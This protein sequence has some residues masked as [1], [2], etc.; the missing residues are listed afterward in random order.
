M[1]DKFIKEAD[2]TKRC[3]TM[4][5][6]KNSTEFMN[7]RRKECK[8][9]VSETEENMGTVGFSQRNLKKYKRARNIHL[10]A[11]R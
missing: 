3:Q 2:S 10:K 9:R 8:D 11:T 4:S 5:A 1:S 7:N 6:I